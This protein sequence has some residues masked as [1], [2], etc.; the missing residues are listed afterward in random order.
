MVELKVDKRQ[1]VLNL[2]R[3]SPKIKEE[4]LYSETTLN[5][6]IYSLRGM[7][8]DIRFEPRFKLISEPQ[9]HLT[10]MLE[11]EGK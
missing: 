8:Y 4:L 3:E 2:L 5:W 11:V 10:D 1:V 7:G 9:N 6:I